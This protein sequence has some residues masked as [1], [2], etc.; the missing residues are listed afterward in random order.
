MRSISSRA[1]HSVRMARLRTEMYARSKVN[2]LSFRSLP[3]PC[4]STIPFS[5]RSTS[6]Q[7]VH[8]FSLFHVLSPC[9]SNTILYMYLLLGRLIL[10]QHI[11]CDGDI[12]KCVWRGG[13]RQRSAICLLYTSPSP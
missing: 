7:P 1:I 3:A 6:V 13:S 11:A 2:P 9:R 10:L 5:D 8:R 12:V 4:A